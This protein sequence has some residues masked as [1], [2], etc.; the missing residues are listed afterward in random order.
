M[1]VVVAVVVGLVVVEP[2]VVAVVVEVAVVFGVAV[3]VGGVAA[4]SVT[5]EP[6]A[7]LLNWLWQCWLQGH[8]LL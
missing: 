6:V 1:A 8:L 5:L 3:V 2:V 7:L 4:Y